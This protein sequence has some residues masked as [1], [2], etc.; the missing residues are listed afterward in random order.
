MEYL[1]VLDFLG[2]QLEPC[3]VV[4]IGENLEQPLV[5]GGLSSWKRMYQHSRRQRRH[6]FLE[7]LLPR[8]LMN[9]RCVKLRRRQ[10]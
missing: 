2:F 7:G 3:F 10:R 8:K 1:V 9:Q 6:C 4:A 5:E